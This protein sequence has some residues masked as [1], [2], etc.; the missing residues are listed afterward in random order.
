M[1]ES[2]EGRKLKSDH[3]VLRGSNSPREG[4]TTGS[5]CEFIFIPQSPEEK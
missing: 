3:C 2:D 4:K 1:P 5:L